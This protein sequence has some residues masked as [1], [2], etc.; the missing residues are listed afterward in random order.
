MIFKKIAAAI[1]A[2]AMAVTGFAVSSGANAN[3]P[4]T[5]TLHFTSENWCHDDE[6]SIEIMGNGTYTISTDSE[7]WI[8]EDNETCANGVRNL[9]IDIEGLGSDL[10]STGKGSIEELCTF[11]DVRVTADGADIPVDQS[12]LIWLYNYNSKGEVRLE[13][14]NEWNVDTKDN[15]SI[16]PD[17]IV[18]ID[19]LSIT[20]T[21]TINEDEPDEPITEPEE[22]DEPIDDYEIRDIFYAGIDADGNFNGKVVSGE[23]YSND[24]GTALE[25]L[26]APHSSLDAY[27][28]TVKSDGTIKIAYELLPATYYKLHGKTLTV[29]SE[30]YGYT[31]SE[32]ESG[33]Q[34]FH[35][36]GFNKIF[37]PDTVTTIG[38]SAFIFCLDLEEVEF[39]ENSQLKLIDQWAFQDCRSLKSI[40]IPA[41]V[42]TIAY[43]AFK[44]SKQELNDVW[45]ENDF[46][47]TYSLTTVKFADGSKLKTLG[48]YAFE[49]QKAL[50]SITLPE[51]LTTISEGAFLECFTLESINI[52]KSVT[53]IGDYAFQDCAALKSVN[54]PANVE[55]VGNYAFSL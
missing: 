45:D 41:S 46:T 23:M 25:I 36:S 15:H 42:E 19:R 54:I 24:W 37:I 10:I 22:P 9:T 30:I 17:D 31:V 34:D 7:T 21:L 39:G 26:D 44:N 8:A 16:N 43:G 40:T 11:S 20:F 3:F 18:D 12:K 49:D 55:T 38:Y 51:G 2:S 1:T 5:A 52:P 29:P 27:R 14:Y 48:E 13:L 4:Y 35:Y 53:T 32:I 28:C 47:D 6:T 50:T 33:D